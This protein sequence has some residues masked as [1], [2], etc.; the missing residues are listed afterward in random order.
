MDAGARA[1]AAQEAG[2]GALTKTEYLL[3]SRQGETLLQQGRAAEAERVFRAL[4]ARLEAGAAYD[5]SLR[6]RD[7]ADAAGPLPGG[8]GA[9][10]AGHRVAA[11]GAGRV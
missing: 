1:R 9:A 7:D 11:P 6:P 8:A 3:A 10:G 5:A 4:L 2:E